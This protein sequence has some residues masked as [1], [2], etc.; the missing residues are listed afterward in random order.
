[1]VQNGYTMMGQ[2]IKIDVVAF[3]ETLS[4]PD[5]PDLLIDEVLSLFYSMDTSLALHSYLFDILV[6]GQMTASY[7]TSAWQAYIAAPGNTANY[8]IVYNRLKSMYKYIMD[9]SEYQLS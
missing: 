4:Q 6:S 5:N 1:M 8:N 2:N 9:L 3:T 7:W